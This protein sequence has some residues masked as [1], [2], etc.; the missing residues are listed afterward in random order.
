MRR[1]QGVRRSDK[2]SERLTREEEAER[3]GPDRTLVDSPLGVAYRYDTDPAG[4]MAAIT[5]GGRL[6]S[7]SHS[8]RTFSS[9][10]RAVGW[11]PATIWSSSPG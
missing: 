2:G 6:A 7:S 9:N 10:V 8:L 1:E 4:S 3:E 5:S 11:P